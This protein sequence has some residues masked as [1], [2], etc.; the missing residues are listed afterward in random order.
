MLSGSSIGSL[1]AASLGT[2]P[3]KSLAEGRTGVLEKAKTNT[4]RRH[5]ELKVEGRR[6]DND[7][8]RASLSVSVTADVGPEVVAAI[9]P[10]EVSGVR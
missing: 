8:E 5:P 6:G 4:R 10:A 2:R 9:V 3:A 1:E 7:E